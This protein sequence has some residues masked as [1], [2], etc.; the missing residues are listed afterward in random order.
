M[1]ATAIIAAAIA[2]AY[3]VSGVQFIPQLVAGTASALFGLTALGMLAFRRRPQ[4]KELGLQALAF[5]ALAGALFAGCKLDVSGARSGALRVA[6]ACEAYKAKTGS[7]PASVRDLVPDYL[8]SVPRARHTIMWAQYELVGEKVMFVLEPGL[9]A[10]GY[11]MSAGKWSVE[12][13]AKMFP[14]R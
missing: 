3:F 6:E 1:I 12:D 8:A 11:D 9:I 14:G 4:A 2:G 5:A 13:V 7:Y 10:Q